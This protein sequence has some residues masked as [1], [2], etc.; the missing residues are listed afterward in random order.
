MAWK[1]KKSKGEDEVVG[2]AAPAAAVA[3]DGAASEASVFGVTEAPVESIF[4]T[5]DNAPRSNGASADFQ[6]HPFEPLSGVVSNFDASSLPSA[7]GEIAGH[8][9]PASDENWKLNAFAP[10]QPGETLNGDSDPAEFGRA[11]SKA[12]EFPTVF[13]DTHAGHVDVGPGEP[14]DTV[15]QPG[16]VDFGTVDASDLTEP[17]EPQMFE[18]L[19]APE[20]SDNADWQ[21]GQFGRPGGTDI[22]NEADEPLVVGSALSSGVGTDVPDA[23]DPDFPVFNPDRTVLNVGYM[24][25]NAPPKSAHVAA[26]P[27][28]A[29][30]SEPVL[31]VHLGALSARYPLGQGE[32]RV[33]R[34]NA[35]TGEAPEIAIDWDDAISRRHARVFSQGTNQYVEDS[36]STNGTLVNDRQIPAHTPVA[37][38]DGD[39]IKVGERTEI[40]FQCE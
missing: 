7:T 32:L 11:N 18:P 6:S 23:A 28:R 27:T 13:A 14:T 12:E 30:G 17:E 35:S 29:P 21:L 9:H 16:M 3:D 22:T 24:P 31:V 26:E 8:E 1:L 15:S 20:V 25:E 38:N 39:I 19:D 40:L 2:E 10:Y 4:T 34:A 33:G 36:G 37:L 5:P